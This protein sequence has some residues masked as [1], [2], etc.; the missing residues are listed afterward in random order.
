[1]FELCYRDVV[2]MNFERALNGRLKYRRLDLLR[3]GYRLRKSESFDA[4]LEASAEDGALLP[5]AARSD[6]DLE[7]EALQKTE[8]DQRQLVDFLAGNINDLD[9]I[10]ALI[11]T[12]FSKYKSVNA[13][14]KALGLHH[15]DVKRKLRRLSRRYDANRFGDYCD[16][17][18]V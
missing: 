11:V 16:Y 15:E 10:T 18:A 8:V 3:E 6:F 4:L 2:Y 5:R 12:E 14:A 7:G 1:M 13:L 17:L 9:P